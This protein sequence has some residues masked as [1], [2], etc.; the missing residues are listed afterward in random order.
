MPDLASE[1]KKVA[2]II[3]GWDD[4]KETLEV[5]RVPLEE[6]KPEGTQF[7]Q[8]TNNVT[9]ECF[10]IIRNNPSKYTIAQAGSSLAM[11]GFKTSSTSS[12]LS[13]MVKQGLLGRN[14]NHTLYA[15]RNEYAPIKASIVKQA[16]RL[17]KKVAAKPMVAAPKEKPQL[18]PAPAPVPPLATLTAANVL[19]TIGIKEAHALYLELH[20]MFGGK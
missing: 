13:S 4:E 6:P 7:F 20:R 1:L 12:I 17:A 5:H 9:R 10:N 2:P 14:E 11:R 16:R 18:A 15:L 8:P 19:Q 3:N